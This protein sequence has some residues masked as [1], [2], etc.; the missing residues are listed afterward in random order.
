MLKSSL[1][2]PCDSTDNDDCG[3]AEKQMH[4]NGDITAVTQINKVFVSPL[5]NRNN[6][7]F[8]LMIIKSNQEAAVHHFCVSAHTVCRSLFKN[9]QYVVYLRR[10]FETTSYLAALFSLKRVHLGYECGKLTKPTYV[11]CISLQQ[12]NVSLGFH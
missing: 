1:A 4:I 11:G 12:H 2:F 5:P 9:K 8:L 3:D 10:M 6:C 7:A